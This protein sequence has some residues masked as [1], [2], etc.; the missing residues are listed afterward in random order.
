VLVI[1]IKI[2]IITDIVRTIDVFA[3]KVIEEKNVK[4]SN[5]L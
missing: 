1:A 5:S 4:I 2:V 3:S